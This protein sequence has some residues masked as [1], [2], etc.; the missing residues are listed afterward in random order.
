[1]RFLYSLAIRF[2]VILI[3]VASLFHPKAKLWV[4]GRKNW[5]AKLREWRQKNPGNL[6]WIHCSSLGEFEQGRPVIE[7]LKK[8]KPGQLIL[9]TFFSPSGR[10]KVFSFKKW[11]L[12]R[13]ASLL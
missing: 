12:G 1:M 6:I 13:C 10:T 3:H 9:L 5:R 11:I 2:Y 4:K 7:S 8:E